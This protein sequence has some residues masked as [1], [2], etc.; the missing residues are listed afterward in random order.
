M[1]EYSSACS[2]E[3]SLQ[4]LGSI[5]MAQGVQ[6]APIDNFLSFSHHATCFSLDCVL[7]D[8]KPVKHC[9]RKSRG[10]GEEGL[11]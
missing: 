7:L 11:T 1:E 6:Q 9:V 10:M 8:L 4:P 2:A 3:K 5:Q